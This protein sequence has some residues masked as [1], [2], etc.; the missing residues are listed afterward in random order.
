MIGWNDEIT[1]DIPAEACF[2]AATDLSQCH[3]W[4]PQIERIERLDKGPLGAGSRW[5]ETRR[6][7]R[8]VHTMELEVFESHSPG[9]GEPP[10]IH[11]AG[12]DIAYMKSYYRFRF[13]AMGQQQTQVYLEARVEPKRYW[14]AFIARPMVRFM[15]K[16]EKGLLDRLKSFCEQQP[17]V[18]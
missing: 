15:K 9:D 5:L 6:E 7:G 12:A 4:I 1:I 16:S 3:Q 2:R 14:M 13:E 11:C 10:Y 18:K 8:R 17:P